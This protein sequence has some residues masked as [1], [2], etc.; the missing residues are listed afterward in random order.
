M[1]T[2][3]ICSIPDCGKPVLNVMR[4]LCKLHYTRWTRGLPPDGR[5]RSTICAVA[6]CES[7]VL[8]KGYCMAHYRRLRLYGDPLGSRPRAK[9]YHK[10]VPVE[11]RF[12]K[13]VD[14]TGEC[15]LWT[16]AKN[17]TGYG[18]FRV[19]HD[20]IILAHR[21][22]YKLANGVLSAEDDVAHSCDT[23]LCV[24]PSH[25][26]AGSTADNIRDAHRKGRAIMGERV[27]GAKLTEENVREARR[28]YTAGE[29]SQRVL[30]ARFGV[31]PHTMRLALRRQTWKHVA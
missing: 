19:T 24:R 15:W 30:A 3:A 23:P 6:D 31:E 22:S 21:F 26:V 28:A 11:D 1:K 20:S 18:Q 7:P 10:T 5:E 2:V 4:Q 9:Y 8:A 17:N 27:T 29:A 25:L 16:G 12:W 13:H 14:K